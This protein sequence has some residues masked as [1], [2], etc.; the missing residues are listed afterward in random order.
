MGELDQK[1]AK[2]VFKMHKTYKLLYLN[3]FDYYSN[4]KVFV[5]TF[6]PLIQRQI[7]PNHLHYKVLILSSIQNSILL[8]VPVYHLQYRYRKAFMVTCSLLL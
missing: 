8:E 6:S 3:K 1:H 4:I 5:I 7:V 2:S